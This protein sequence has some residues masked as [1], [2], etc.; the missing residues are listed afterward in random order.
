MERVVA[1]AVE[2]GL[3]GGVLVTPGPDLVWL[4]GYQPTAI[5]ERLTV[6]VLRPDHEPTLLA[7]LLER[8]DAEAAAGAA[9]LTIRDWA[10][11]SDPY[12]VAGGLLDPAGRYAVSD[13]AW[14]MHLL[15]LQESLPATRYE[16]MTQCLPMLRAVKDDAEL[17]RL[18]AA[19]AAADSA[20][21]EVVKLRFAGRRETEVAADL[22]GLLREFG[23]EQVDFTVVGSGPNG[24]NPHHEAGERV[25]EVGDAVVLDFGG[26]HERVRLRHHAHGLRGGAQRRARHACTASSGRPSRRPSRRSDRASPARRS[27]GSPG[28]S[29]PQAG[30][31]EQFIHRTGHGI[32][33]TTH[34]PPYMVEG[35][36]QPLRAGDVLL[37][38]ARASTSAG[39]SACGS[40]TS[41][42]SPQTAGAG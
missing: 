17:A 20:F 36:L 29:S 22:A 41:S 18:A 31:G 24:A 12:A 21:L 7:P 6:L 1:D 8:P 10:D 28:R 11:G 15:G 30:Y 2:A 27:T 25:I 38:R 14:A 19:G 9:A 4:T 26:L 34:E 37:H 35:E 5:T 40:R 33:V 42:P 16:A 39:A 3:D 13:S 32:G 23:H